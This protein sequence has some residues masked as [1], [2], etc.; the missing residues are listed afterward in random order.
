MSK[1][2]WTDATWNP[3]ARGAQVTPQPSRVTRG[4]H[5]TCI[6]CGAEIVLA[7]RRHKRCELCRAFYKTPTRMALDTLD[8]AEVAEL[9][10]VI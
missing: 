7:H 5:A 6:E 2:E 1:I 8:P 4:R 10:E 3:R 9:P